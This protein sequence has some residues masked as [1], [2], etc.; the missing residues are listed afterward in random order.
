MQRNLW[1]KN[2]YVKIP[3]STVAQKQ[4]KNLVVA[5][6]PTIVPELGGAI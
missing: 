5:G 3:R 6:E 4:P 1:N 2:E